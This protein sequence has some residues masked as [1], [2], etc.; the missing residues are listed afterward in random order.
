LRKFGRFDAQSFIERAGVF[1]LGSRPAIWIGSGFEL[2]DRCLA[3]VLTYLHLDTPLLDALF[4]RR[5]KPTL[6]LDQSAQIFDLTGVARVA[7]DDTGEPGAME[8]THV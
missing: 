1:V 6:V 7:V 2:G 4:L 3:F 8:V 5:R